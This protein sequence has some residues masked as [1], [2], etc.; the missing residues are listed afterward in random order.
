MKISA[1]KGGIRRIMVDIPPDEKVWVD[2]KPGELTLEISDKVKAAFA[3]G[4]ETD[5]AEIMLGPV[6]VDWDLEEEVLDADGNPTGEMRHLSP[7]EGLKKVPVEFLG[8]VLNAVQEDAVPNP[9]RFAT[10]NGASQQ[11][12]EVA[13]PSQSGTSSS[14][15]P[16]ASDV[17]RGSFSD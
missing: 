10:S 8:R 17:D 2:Y 3:A 12:D 4:F 16:T 11:T 7:K 6:L 1:L 13:D 9:Q 15:Q 14:E 5:I